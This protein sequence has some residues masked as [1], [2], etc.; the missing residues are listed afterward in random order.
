ML[1]EK[2]P[3]KNSKKRRHRCRLWIRTKTVSWIARKCVRQ[4]VRVV[5]RA[6]R[7]DRRVVLKDVDVVLVDRVLTA[8]RQVDLAALR[9]VGEVRAA[10][11]PTVP[12]VREVL[13]ARDRDPVVLGRAPWGHRV[14]NDLLST[15]WSSTLTRMGSS[16]VRN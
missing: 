6:R 12:V 9:G 2:S 13:A 15:R 1:T 7:R 4:E 10:P 3:K 16:A 5:L 8:N 14:L 11:G